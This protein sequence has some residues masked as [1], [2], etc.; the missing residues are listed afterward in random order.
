MSALD[1]ARARF[2][3][4]RASAHVHL[5]IP[6]WGDDLIARVE[7][8][9]ETALRAMTEREAD[10]LDATADMIDAAVVGLFSRGD[11]GELVPLGDDADGPAPRFAELGPILGEPSSTTGRAG[12]Y[13]AFSLGDPPVLNVTA[14]GAFAGRIDDW[15]ADTSTKIEGAVAPGR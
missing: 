11:D 15:L 14:L 7:I 5:P 6:G 13:L 10:G 9:D 8:I 3:K 2:E 1:R 4:L 12:V